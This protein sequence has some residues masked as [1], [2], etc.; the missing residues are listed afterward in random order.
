MFEEHQQVRKNLDGCFKEFG[1]DVALHG[2][3]QREDD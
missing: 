3:S 1:S 2:V